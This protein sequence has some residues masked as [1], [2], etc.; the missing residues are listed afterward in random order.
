MEELQERV[1]WLEKVVNEL[2]RVVY[3]H[4]GAI[5]ETKRE[6]GIH[7]HLNDGAT[8]P[9]VLRTGDHQYKRVSQSSVAVDALDHDPSA[10]IQEHERDPQA[11]VKRVY[12][13]LFY[14]PWE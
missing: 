1:A 12:G 9:L 2:A 10:E 7:Y 6:F 14:W 11:F 13:D 3:L 8:T 5:A 4:A